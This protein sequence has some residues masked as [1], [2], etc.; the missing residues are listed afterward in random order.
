[1]AVSAL[2]LATSLLATRPVLAA[3]GAVDPTFGTGGVTFAPPL[4]DGYGDVA[5]LPDGRIVVAGTG[6][7]GY[8]NLL[9]ARYTSRGVLDATFGQ[10][11]QSVLDLGQDEMGSAM[12]IQADGKIVVAGT[13][14]PDHINQGTEQLVV[15]RFLPNGSLDTLFGTGG[16]VI[17]GTGR[18][19]AKVAVALQPDGRILV[20]YSV[21]S[22][23]DLPAVIRLAQDGSLDESFGNGR[24]GF[25]EPVAGVGLPF[26]LTGMEVLPDGRI[27]VAGTWEAVW[28]EGGA[29]VARLTADGQVDP[30]YGSAGLARTPMGA[31]GWV[32]GTTLQADGSI[33]LAGSSQRQ[34]YDP[35]FVVARIT[36]AGVPDPSFGARG[37][38][39]VRIAGVASAVANDVSLGPGGSL[40]VAG[41]ASD[42]AVTAPATLRGRPFV[43]RFRSDGTLEPRYGNWGVATPMAPAPGISAGAGPIAVQ[44]DGAAVVVGVTQDYPRYRHFIMRLL[45]LAVGT[46]VLGWGWN[47]WGQVGDGSTVQRH[48]AVAVPGRAEMVAVSAGAYHNLALAPDGS[49]WAWGWNRFGQ[50]GD[51]TAV[52]RHTP[53]RVAGLTGVVALSAGGFHSLAVKADGSVWAWGWNGFGQLGDG[54]TVERHAPVRVVGLTGT[55]VRDVSGGA[56]HS[57][58]L[59]EDGSARAWGWNGFGQ[60]GDG[61]TIERHAPV[62]VN[63]LAHADALAAGAYHNLALTRD[64]TVQAWGFNRFGQLGDGTTV[65]RPRP[66]PVPGLTGMVALA[67]GS[68]FHSLAVKGDGSAWGWGWNGYGQ[69]GDGTTVE[70]HAPVRVVGAGPFVGV[71]GGG[72]HSVAVDRSGRLSAWGWNVLGQLGDGTTVDRHAP[73]AVRVPAGA[74]VAIV[75]GGAYHSVAG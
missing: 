38:A 70:R 73:T 42:G 22:S 12:A 50:L 19:R 30:T 1:M 54:T 9:V 55:A 32:R 18:I 7:N 48:A 8:G 66:V 64:G 58:A 65:Q 63:G 74:A 15:A 52:E 51:G 57:I 62:V 53:V 39:S 47:G 68:W 37:E 61:T 24:P 6:W 28:G 26:Q 20:G 31:G 43:A 69:V 10:G 5:L 41:Q 46:P 36:A 27:L 67:E 21:R 72:F 59:V 60:L 25:D 40:Y 45:P 2:L 16:S 75:S 3:P 71:S 13:R 4:N 29:A 33:V 44:S 23:E 34:G 17:K 56:F 14:S 11:G 49:V 35:R